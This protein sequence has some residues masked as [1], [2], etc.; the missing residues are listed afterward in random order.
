MH[1]RDRGC[2]RSLFVYATCVILIL[3]SDL[4]SIAPTHNS[5]V[6]LHDVFSYR[7]QMLE[8]TEI[9]THV[10]PDVDTNSQNID[11]YPFIV[12]IFA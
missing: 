3:S 10:I 1:F 12:D 7:Q 2:V 9:H 8:S 6:F 11:K 4:N 5:I